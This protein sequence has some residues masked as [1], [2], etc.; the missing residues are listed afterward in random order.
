MP[1]TVLIVDAVATNRIVLK[2]KL[3]S[4]YYDTL[5]AS[6][7]EEALRRAGERN[8]GAILLGEVDGIDSAELVR[9][10]R[11]NPKTTHIPLLVLLQGNDVSTRLTVL[12]AGADDVVCKPIDDVVLL[13]RLRSLQRARE[14]DSELSMRESTQRAL[15]LSEAPAGFGMQGRIAFLH[16]N[17]HHTHP[18]VEDIEQKIPHKVE[19][20]T[21]RDLMSGKSSAATSEAAD[22]YVIV[23]SETTDGTLGMQ[24]L[25]ELR[26]RAETRHAAIVVIAPDA[27]RRTGA[28][29]LDLGANDLVRTQDLSVP[30]MLWRLDKHV[31]R[32]RKADRLRSTTR[33]GLR[34][35]ATDPLTGLFN[36][37]YAMPHL[38]RIAD[39]AS[40]TGR[41]FAVMI[42]D[43]DHFKLVN[44]KYGHAAGDAVLAGVADRLRDQL[45]A[46]DMVARLG[47]EEFLI[48]MPDTTRRAAIATARRLCR[49]ISDHPFQIPGEVSE[50]TATVSIGVAMGGPSAP[51][52]GHFAT[53]GMP[54]A[55]TLDHDAL[56]QEADR[57]LY[58][59]KAQGRNTVEF[60]N[61]A[62]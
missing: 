46:V 59:A 28:T 31:E 18:V 19:R 25:P 10:F 16:D 36:R 51:R 15:G 9:R 4:A 34:A 2:V 50:L 56:L 13:A 49:L 3:S 41:S 60:Y 21:L 45:R 47:G 27:L 43:L 42:A 37:R 20:V 8:P 61:A 44:D 32:K 54:V 26:T 53:P 57:A 11:G 12:Q 24:L 52:S 14:A 7:A 33:D 6:S 17:S 35:A 38:E 23:L 29:L 5:Q 39:R 62:A 58:E 1:G 22:V 30:E 40:R 55:A 48:I